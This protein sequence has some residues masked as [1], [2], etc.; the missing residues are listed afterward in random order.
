MNTRIKSLSIDV[1]ESITG[2]KL[3]VLG[4][5]GLEESDPLIFSDDVHKSDVPSLEYMIIELTLQQH[6]YEMQTISQRYTIIE[7]RHIDE[8]SLQV[9]SYAGS[10]QGETKEFRVY[11]DISESMNYG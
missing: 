6:G 4:G 9:Y 11:F 8:L 10:D 5:G 3:P 1:V 2:N 7:N